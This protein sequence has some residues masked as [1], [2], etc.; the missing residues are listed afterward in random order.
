[1]EKEATT[2]KPGTAAPDD[3][4]LRIDPRVPG[5]I[6][7]EEGAEDVRGPTQAGAQ[8]ERLPAVPPLL[9]CHGQGLWP[10][11]LAPVP[12]VHRPARAAADTSCVSAEVSRHR[13]H[14]AGFAR[15]RSGGGR[16][17]ARGG[18]QWGVR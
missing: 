10:P 8:I 16:V 13:H 1:M 11:L 12:P 7:D 14:V 6:E 5:Y 18:A 2:T 9:G 3:L 4:M 15:R 17:V